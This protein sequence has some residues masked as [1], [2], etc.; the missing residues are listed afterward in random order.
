MITSHVSYP[1]SIVQLYSFHSFIVHDFGTHR[2]KMTVTST[3]SPQRDGG[4]SGSADKTPILYLDINFG[5]DEIQ[6]IV[7]HEGDEPEQLVESFGKTHGLDEGKKAKL[8]EIIQIQL[9][10]V[11]PKIDEELE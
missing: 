11:L 3:S 4:D 2:E 1:F 6:R 7:V 5:K 8:I 9:K 10:N